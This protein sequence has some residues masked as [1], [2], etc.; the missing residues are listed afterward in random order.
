MDKNIIQ[1]LKKL[2]IL[3]GNSWI[4]YEFF[5]D[6]DGF[7]F[8]GYDD[9]IFTIESLFDF[10]YLIGGDYIPQIVYSYHDSIQYKITDKFVR[11]FM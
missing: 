8:K 4:D 1:Y 7:K 11:E 10:G 3:C 6:G 5:E 2:Y 9:I